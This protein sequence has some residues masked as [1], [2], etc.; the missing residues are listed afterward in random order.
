MADHWPSHMFFGITVRFRVNDH[1]GERPMNAR[2]S[3]TRLRSR[4]LTAS[5]PLLLLVLAPMIS[6][7][8]SPGGGYPPPS[9]QP[10]AQRPRSGICDP[11]VKV[12]V[13]GDSVATMVRENWSTKSP[14]VAPDLFRE[15]SKPGATIG[16]DVGAL[17]ELAQQTARLKT[18]LARCTTKHVVAYVLAGA[19]DL[20]YSSSAQTPAL[21]DELIDEH[22]LPALAAVLAQLHAFPQ[23]ARVSAALDTPGENRCGNNLACVLE[24]ESG[25]SKLNFLINSQLSNGTLTRTALI[26][27]FGTNSYSTYG[28]SP[29]AGSFNRPLFTD[30]GA[31][32]QFDGNHPNPTVIDRIA[33]DLVMETQS[34]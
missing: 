1:M 22:T 28:R 8:P 14:K 15:Y 33:N 20:G 3:S 19:N 12:V 18:D 32:P 11:E 2:N 9:T 6:C 29:T 16:T 10:S 4:L 31:Y 13:L 21:G 27:H 17:D 24:M 25:I 26:N 30:E 7:A 5:R 23:I 34:I